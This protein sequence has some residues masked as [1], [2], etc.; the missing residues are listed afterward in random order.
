MI[1]KDVFK[2]FQPVNDNTATIDYIITWVA[3]YDYHHEAY[4]PDIKISSDCKPELV[5]S[6]K[7]LNSR[8]IEMSAEDRDLVLIRIE[9]LDECKSKDSII[10]IA[11]NIIDSWHKGDNND[12]T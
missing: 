8:V 12:N 3:L 11:S 2:L 9:K 5:L 10:G 4:H 6:E 7:V 1:V